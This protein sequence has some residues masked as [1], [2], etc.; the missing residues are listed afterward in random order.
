MKD[1]DV[2]I[3]PAEIRG[4]LLKALDG[5]AAG[6]IDTRTANRLS[7]AV[8]R[9]NSLMRASHE[10][11]TADQRSEFA[12]IVAELREADRMLT[13]LLAR[14]LNS[15]IAAEDLNASNDE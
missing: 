2:T 3:D 7:K 9:T 12:S 1:Q 14:N 5:L 8:K 13:D 15:T 6:L 4:V 10:G 11:A